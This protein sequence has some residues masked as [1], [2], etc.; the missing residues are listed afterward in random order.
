V[1][2]QL[3]PAWHRQTF[4]VHLLADHID[5]MP[6]RAELVQGLVSGPFAVYAGDA[7]RVGH[8]SAGRR[9]YT[10]LHLPSQ[11]PKLKLP[12]IGL[13]R[14]AAL[15]FAECDLAWENA[16]APDVTG[17]DLEKAREVH[18]RWIGWREL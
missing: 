5:G 4:A 15:D 6:E 9:S 2:L 17:P 14:Q 13:C 3:S 8:R 1:K 7:F 11:T 18:R 16:W 10:L 12:R